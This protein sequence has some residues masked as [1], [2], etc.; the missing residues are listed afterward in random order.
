LSSGGG[1]GF[2]SWGFAQRM[3]E[4]RPKNTARIPC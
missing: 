3:F 1:A 4:L 2:L